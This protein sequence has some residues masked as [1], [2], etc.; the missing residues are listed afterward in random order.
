MGKTRSAWVAPPKQGLSPNIF[1]R[2]D[3]TSGDAFEQNRNTNKSSSYTATE[4][5]APTVA[6]PSLGV[7][8]WRVRGRAGNG[9]GG[10]GE[11]RGRGGAGRGQRQGMG[12]GAEEEG[13]PPKRPHQSM[14][15]WG[16]RPSG[17]DQQKK[18]FV[19][20]AATFRATTGN[21]STVANQCGANIQASS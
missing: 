4:M 12:E 7:G 9:D 8:F 3:L 19:C 17:Q 18:Q 14:H 13:V 1:E 2:T 10:R 16:W 15:L 21:K 6:A 20:G 11:G 5:R